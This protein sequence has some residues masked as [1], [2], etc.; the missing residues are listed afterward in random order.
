MADYQIIDR[1]DSHKLAGVLARDGQFLLPLVELI[2]RA[3]MAVDELIDVAG[4]ATIE[5]VL[6]L[7]ARELAGP[8]QPGKSRGA[9]RWYGR[10]RGVVHLAE[11][12]LRVSRPRLRRKGQRRDAEVPIPA[13][14]AMQSSGPLA[15]RMLEILLAGIS[16]RQYEHVLP[17]MAETCG[18]SRMAVSRQFVE[19]SVEELQ[20]LLERRFDDVDLLVIYLDGLVFGQ[21]HVLAA[22]GVDSQGHKHVLGLRQGASENAEVAKALLED[23]VGRGVKPGRRRLFVIDGSKALKKAIDQVYGGDNPVQRCRNHKLRNVLGHLPKE[24]HDQARATLKAAFKLDAEEGLAK[25]EQYAS[26][27]QRDWPSAAASL[28][29]GLEEL[30]TINRLGLP[31]SLRRCW[32][33]TN[34]I[35]ASH[36]GVRR[37][38]RRVTH[39]R[40]GEMVLRWAAAA[41]VATEKKYRRIMGYQ[42]LWMLKAHLDEPR[43]QQTLEEEK[44]AG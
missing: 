36:S 13:Y 17:E 1:T 41:L 35:D 31:A 11:R 12:K 9:L 32:S 15:R 10:Q 21:Q 24:Q 19:A 14:E 27:L 40:D 3:E 23:L 33:T 29:E 18:V 2:E 28:R 8:K 6:E 37:K 16:T 7:S 39:W 26:W 34:L 22:V 30:F 44:K 4:R 43:D 42:Q 5:A 25:I 20:A 38:T